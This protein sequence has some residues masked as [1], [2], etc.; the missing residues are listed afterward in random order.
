MFPHRESNLKQKVVITSI[1]STGALNIVKALRAQRSYEVE[2]IGLD[3]SS[4]VAGRHLVDRF[5]QVPWPQES[6]YVSSVAQICAD[7]N[8]DLLIPVMEAELEVLAQS[9]NHDMR[10]RLVASSAKT[11]ATCNDKLLTHQF[12]IDHGIPT[13]PV[14]TA[15]SV[16]YPAILKPIHGTGSKGVHRVDDPDSLSYQLKGSSEPIFLQQF[17]TGH[18]Y[19]IDTF[20]EFQGK[21]IGGVPRRRLE[22]KNG[23]ATKSV[24]VHDDELL[25]IA[26]KI[27][28]K[29]PIRGPA[30]VQCIKNDCGVFVTDVNPKFGGAFL[31]SIEAGLNAPLF[32]LN[33][34]AGDPI[35]Y[36]GYVE[37]LMMLRY[38]QEVF[39]AVE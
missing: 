11:V 24:T 13:P 36:S 29:L 3:A 15:E 28:E 8:A 32:L 19:T 22:V 23:L 20:S 17:V 2:I 18:E 26:R 14:Y 33:L 39:V 27:C 7:C 31:L 9:W 25:N 4:Q 30:N 37:N 34:V 16:E 38:W 6:D 12:L 5:W 35:Q 10:G 21:F 1:G